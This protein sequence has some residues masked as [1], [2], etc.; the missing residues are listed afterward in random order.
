MTRVKTK[1]KKKKK[2]KKENDVREMAHNTLVRPQLEYA[3]VV[4]DPRTKDKISQRTSDS[5]D[6][7]LPTK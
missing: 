5:S 7:N 2:R 3:A 1:K 4:Y 6:V